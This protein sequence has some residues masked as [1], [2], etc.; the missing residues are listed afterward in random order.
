MKPITGTFCAIALVSGLALSGGA[1]APALAGGSLSVELTPRN[2][3][4]ARAMRA[5][6]GIYALVQGAKKSADVTQRGNRNAAAIGQRGNGHYGAVHQEGND[7]DAS[8][9]Q[10]GNGNAYGIFQFGNGAR[11]HAT[12]RGNGATG[13]L[14]QYG[15]K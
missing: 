10:S 9:R 6:L 1:A 2:A 14:I 5:G 8:L 4:E 15:W 13:M 7:H 12:Q 3:D 11:G